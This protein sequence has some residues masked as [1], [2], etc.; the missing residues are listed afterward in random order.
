MLTAKKAIE[1][2]LISLY[3]H[4]LL[5]Q[6]QL[7]IL[8][9]YKLSYIYTT[10]SEINRE[11]PEFL[12]STKIPYLTRNRK[13]FYIKQKGAYFAAHITKEEDLYNPKNFEGPPAQIRHILSNNEFFIRLIEF[14]R[15]RGGEGL[16]EWLGTRDA[17]D[18]YAQFRDET[19]NRRRTDLRPD[20]YGI[21]LF[22]DKG[23][24]FIHTELDTGTETLAR[25]E[26]KMRNYVRV[27]Q[28]FWG[29][30]MD[31]ANILFITL[32]NSRVKRILDIWDYLRNGP[33]KGQSLPSVWCTWYTD[34]VKLGPMAN[35]WHGHRGDSELD[36]IISLADMPLMA[37]I[38][39][40]E[41]EFLGKQKNEA[42]LEKKAAG[43]AAF[44]DDSDQEDQEEI[45]PEPGQAIDEVNGPESVE[46]NNDEK[47]EAE[48]EKEESPAAVFWS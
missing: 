12:G 19:T 29:D 39:Y 17:G 3:R 7:S 14:S 9:N 34:M 21:Y 27:L 11:D 44:F 35:I 48:A 13:T 20:G 32:V 37:P 10:I 15:G 31:K 8:L 47:Q 38:Y 36:E 24:L 41:E 45:Q 26:D 23:R 5:T 18:R 1:Q 6:Q 30:N 33:L 4:S 16:V 43:E 22:P 28:H 2:I 40:S 25:I 46:I 42:L